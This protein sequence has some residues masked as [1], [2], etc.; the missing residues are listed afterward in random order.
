MDGI[1][2]LSW[3]LHPAT[4]LRNRRGRRRPYGDP[5]KMVL[6]IQGF[7][8]AGVGCT[9]WAMRYGNRRGAEYQAKRRLR[10]QLAPGAGSER[11]P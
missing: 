9:L 4:A 10:G 3:R 11:F 6:W 5:E 8:L 1:V 2:E 7:R